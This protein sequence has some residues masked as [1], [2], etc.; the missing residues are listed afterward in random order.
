MIIDTDLT[1]IDRMVKALSMTK[2][3]V[4]TGGNGYIG[5]HLQKELKKQGYTVI[6][7]D[8]KIGRAHV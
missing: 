2:K 3:A 1:H 7:V 5:H 6:V 8:K 4:I